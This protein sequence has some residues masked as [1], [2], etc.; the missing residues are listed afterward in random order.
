MFESIYFTLKLIDLVGG[1]VEGRKR[2]QKLA[3]IMKMKKFPLRYEFFYHHYGPYSPELNLEMSELVSQELV[4]EKETNAGYEYELTSKGKNLINLLEE[5]QL[6]KNFQAG[7]ELEQLAKNIK[8]QEPSLL[9]LTSTILFI[10]DYGAPL[11]KAVKEAM[12]LKPHLR[13]YKEKAVELLAQL[14]FNQ[15]S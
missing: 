10:H 14:G 11:E 12:E 2:L 7:E 15:S 1:K 9:E 5:K 4:K 13:S 3:Y 8:N 6:V